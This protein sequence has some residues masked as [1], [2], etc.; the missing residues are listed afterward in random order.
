MGGV[1]VGE[2]VIVGVSVIVGEGSGVFEGVAGS[3]VAVGWAAT[4]V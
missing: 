4:A 2:G 3:T 1:S